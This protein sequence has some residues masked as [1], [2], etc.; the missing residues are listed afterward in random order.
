M[1][2]KNKLFRIVGFQTNNILFVKNT[3]FADKKQ[4]NLKKAQFLAKNQD[5]LIFDKS[6]KF[7]KGLIYIN[8][9][10]IILTQKC[11]CKNLKPVEANPTIIISSKSIV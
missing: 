6:I 11:Q 9:D 5:Q 10:S 3:K 7:N 1:L 2:Y 4:N 8:I